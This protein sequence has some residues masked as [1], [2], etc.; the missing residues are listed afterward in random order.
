MGYQQ[1]IETAKKGFEDA[2]MAPINANF[3]Q[4]KVG[5]AKTTNVLEIEK[6]VEDVVKLFVPEWQ[7]KQ[8]Q[9]VALYEGGN[10]GELYRTRALF[11]QDGEFF[12]VC[13]VISKISK[14][15]EGFWTRSPFKN[16]ESYR[17]EKGKWNIV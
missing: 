8:R 11:E 13:A 1:M 12:E 3:I 2:G 5:K 15:V 7:G 16:V 4:W 9:I 6:A 10:E 14:K 17:F